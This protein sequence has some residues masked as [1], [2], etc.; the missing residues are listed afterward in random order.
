[1]ESSLRIEVAEEKCSEKLEVGVAW[2]EVSDETVEMESLLEKISLVGLVD[3][4]PSSPAP[5]PA[6]ARSSHFPRTVSR[7]LPT[8]CDGIHLFLRDE[9]GISALSGVE[10]AGWDDKDEFLDAEPRPVRDE[11]RSKSRVW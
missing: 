5:A 1:V 11:V 3:L 2:E 10:G 4:R 6:L 7:L 8:R 9:G